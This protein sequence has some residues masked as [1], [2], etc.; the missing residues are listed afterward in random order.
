MA[1]ITRA[2]FE[3]HIKRSSVGE[4][5]AVLGEYTLYSVF[6]PIYTQQLKLHGFEALLR[7]KDAQGNWIRPDLFLS[8]PDFNE[9]TRLSAEMLSR[10]IHLR[11]FSLF[12]PHLPCKIF[13][14]VIPAALISYQRYVNSIT[15][16][17]THKLM[18]IRL[19]ELGI[20]LDDVVLEIVEQDCNENEE[21]ARLISGIKDRGYLLAIDDFGAGSSDTNRVHLI[22]PDMIKIDRSL[23]LTYEAGNKQP[24]LKAIELAVTTQSKVLIEGIETQQQLDIIELLPI[25]FYQGYQLGKPASIFHWLEE[26]NAHFDN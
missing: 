6:Q 19:E 10:A 14:N 11:N 21:L 2:D 13:L 15:N 8:N 5:Y 24:L 17:E 26:F 16:S 18:R 1:P 22:E 12:Y 23:L 3:R 25:D 4:S 9:A 20:K 7:I